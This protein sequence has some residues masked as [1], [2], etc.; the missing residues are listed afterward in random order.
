MVN[1][2]DPLGEYK[3][4]N[5]ESNFNEIG[6]MATPMEADML[7]GYFN[8]DQAIHE[9]VSSNDM[10]HGVLQIHVWIYIK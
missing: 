6:A 9:Y 2:R 5:T 1:N 8:L 4:A 10:S 7:I 3:T